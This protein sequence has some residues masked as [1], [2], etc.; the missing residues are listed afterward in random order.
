MPCI[1]IASPGNG[2]LA[3]CH[4]EVTLAQSCLTR[5][6]IDSGKKEPPRGLGFST[7]PEFEEELAWMRAFV[8]EEVWP[9]ETIEHDIGQEELD[10]INAPL[11]KRVRE[12]GLWAAHLPPELSGWGFGRVKL[13]LMNKILGT[14]IYAPLVSGCHPTGSARAWHGRTC[15]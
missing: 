15:R 6:S 9:I 7:E 5:A 12:R 13:G 1:A 8:R 4:N 10:R 14:S 2:D 3:M 11:Q